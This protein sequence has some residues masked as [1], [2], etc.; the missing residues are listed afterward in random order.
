[1][2]RQTDRQTTCQPRL[3]QQPEPAG[4]PEPIYLTAYIEPA[5]HRTC[6][7]TSQNLPA[8]DTEPA[9][10]RARTCLLIRQTDRQPATQTAT[11]TDTQT[12]TQTDTQ[13]STQTDTRTDT[14]TSTQTDT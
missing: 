5:S 11:Q 12:S 8:S 9:S 2:T 6:L 1:M 14:Q 7:P 13:T 4:A 10:R 3:Y